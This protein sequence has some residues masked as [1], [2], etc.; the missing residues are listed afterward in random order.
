MIEMKTFKEYIAESG[1]LVASKDGLTSMRPAQAGKMDQ[2]ITDWIRKFGKD[3]DSNTTWK[4]IAIALD[5]G[6]RDLWNRLLSDR[7]TGTPLDVDT[8]TLLAELAKILG[9]KL[10]MVQRAWKALGK[11]P[12]WSEFD[13]PEV[14]R[15]WVKSK[16]K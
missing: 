16:R 3:D 8:P 1:I 14:V 5:L 2:K 15:K 9:A 11:A 12:R 7:K 10:D 4:D 13:D 6:D